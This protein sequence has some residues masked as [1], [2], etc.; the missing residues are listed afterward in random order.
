MS[1]ETI[2]VTEITLTRDFSYSDTEALSKESEEALLFRDMQADLLQQLL[3]RLAAVK[4]LG[5]P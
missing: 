5:A 2:P 3:R 1:D 4:S